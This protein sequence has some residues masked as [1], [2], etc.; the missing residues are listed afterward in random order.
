[1]CAALGAPAL[2]FEDLEVGMAD[3]SPA[4]TVT[5]A[6]LIGFAGLSGDFNPIHTDRELARSL[7]PGGE[8]IV[9]GLLALSIGSGLFTR[10]PLGAALSAQV[11]A[12]L[13]LRTRFVAPVRIGDTVR[14]RSAIKDLRPTSKPGSGVTV[15]DRL[16]VRHD[17]DTAQETEVTLL[18][19]CR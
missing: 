5:E 2:F 15:M 13:E 7:A 16:L 19:K 18:V 6:D 10:S 4:R 12:M 11:V 14:V 3:T 9:H 8:I 17:D 1:M